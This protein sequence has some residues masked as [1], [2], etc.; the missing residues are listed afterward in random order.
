MNRKPTFYVAQLIVVIAITSVFSIEHLY[1][2][3]NNE[4]YY[5]ASQ[6]DDSFNRYFEEWAS[7]SLLYKKIGIDLRYEAHIPPAPGNYNTETRHGISLRTLSFQSKMITIKAGHFYTI[8]GRGLTLRTFEKRELGWDT[9]I[10]GLLFKYVNEKIDLTLLGGIP[11]SANGLKYDPLEAGEISFMPHDFL[12]LGATMVLTNRPLHNSYWE[13]LYLSLNLPFGS[14]YTEYASQT[15]S[16]L[17]KPDTTKALYI[18][19]TLFIKDFSLLAEYK[20][21]MDFNLDQG[22][23]YNNPPPVTKEHFF[24]LLNRHQLLSN[25][26]DELGFLF[27]ATYPVIEDNLL[28]VSYGYSTNKNRTAKYHD[29]YTQLGF[30]LPQTFDW[31]LAT[32]FQKENWNRHITMIFNPTWNINNRYSLKLEFQHQHTAVKDFENYIKIPKFYTQYYS[33]S[34]GIYPDISISIFIE[35][36]TDK[37][38]QSDFKIERNRIWIGG[39]L[40]LTILESHNLTF[41]AGTRRGGKNCT[42]G[43]CKNEPALKGIELKITSN[44]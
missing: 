43:I 32:G 8:L 5:T 18:T 19:T 16:E 2:T 31:I 38:A 42:T 22:M 26:D 24:A 40:G 7:I 3:G 17:F 29:F 21:Y 6:K 23:V 33:V 11:Y 10:D 30:Q 15:L 14:I 28:T 44:F 36:T 4:L 34:L 27:E 35:T 1:L 12:Q 25:A 41:F 13:S 37:F 39:E 20:Y 9:K